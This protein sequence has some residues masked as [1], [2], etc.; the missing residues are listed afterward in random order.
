MKWNF[1]KNNT[2]NSND[3]QFGADDISTT[4]DKRKDDLGKRDFN[5]K[6]RN[7][8]KTIEICYCCEIVPHATFYHRKGHFAKVCESTENPIKDTNRV[9]QQDQT[10]S[11]DIYPST[12][13]D[14]DILT[15]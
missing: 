14:I 1:L 3:I 13:A 12:M 9:T 4:D 15:Y 6:Q 7:F 2:L 11:N 8:K 5:N 10:Q